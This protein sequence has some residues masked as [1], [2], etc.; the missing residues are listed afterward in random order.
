MVQKRAD[1]VEWGRRPRGGNTTL[2]MSGE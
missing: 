1:V 2:H